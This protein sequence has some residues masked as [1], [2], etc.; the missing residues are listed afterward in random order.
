MS[1]EKKS[2]ITDAIYNLSFLAVLTVGSAIVAVVVVDKL[3]LERLPD[4]IFYSTVA[5][6][7]IIFSLAFLSIEIAVNNEKNRKI[8]IPFSIIGIVLFVL[9]IALL[10]FLS[11]K[12]AEYIVFFI[13]LAV[14]GGVIAPVGAWQ[15]KIRKEEENLS[16][17]RR[18]KKEYSKV[19]IY[20]II[21]KQFK[22]KMYDCIWHQYK[23][24][25]YGCEKYRC[26][27]QQYSQKIP[28]CIWQEN[29]PDIKCVERK[30][31][32]EKELEL[33]E[34]VNQKIAELKEKVS[35]GNIDIDNL[36]TELAEVFGSL[37]L[38]V[39]LR[40]YI[41][42]KIGESSDRY[43]DFIIL[44]MYLKMIANE[45]LTKELQEA[46]DLEKEEITIIERIY[47]LLN[48]NSYCKH[49]TSELINTIE[50]FSKIT[51]N[52][53]KDFDEFYSMCASQQE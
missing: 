20:S 38:I 32:E 6:L 11:I 4:K 13:S 46:I 17:V 18:K 37:L 30:E 36:K 15:Y 43:R 31:I 50:E 10:I 52:V 7:F 26:I 53:F 49:D 2:S 14:I 24:K 34:Q 9:D 8:S 12:H 27:W 29:N 44:I 23:Q 51:K 41:L 28:G 35:N 19:N 3:G 25:I 47:L 48:S 16:E 45:N 1:E 22:Q 42:Y 5:I 40:G 33:F 21:D 39:I